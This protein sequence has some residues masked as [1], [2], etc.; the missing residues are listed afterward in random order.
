MPEL[1]MWD[2]ENP[3]TIYDDLINRCKNA[4]E[5]I[6][7]CFVDESW[8]PPKG[9][10]PI[11]FVIIDGI[12]VCRVVSSSHRE[13]MLQVVDNIPVIKSLDEMKDD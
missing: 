6:I 10:F 1:E 4:K 12:Y 8:V 5:Y 11:D 7:R 13:A 2:P 3:Q 9:K